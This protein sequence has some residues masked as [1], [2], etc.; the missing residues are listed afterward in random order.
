MAAAHL[1]ILLMFIIAKGIIALTQD[2][3]KGSAGH[4][5]S[6]LAKVPFLPVCGLEEGDLGVG[7]TLSEKL[8]EFMPQLLVF[9]GKMRLPVA[10]YYLYLGGKRGGYRGGERGEFSTGYPRVIPKLSTYPQAGLSTG[11]KRSKK[12]VGVAPP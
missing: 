12:G 7:D 8:T 4:I 9:R 11:K 3:V 5:F 2:V 6:F 1:I 10:Y